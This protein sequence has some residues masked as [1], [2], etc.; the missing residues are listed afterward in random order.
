MAERTLKKA[1]Y[2]GVWTTDFPTESGEYWVW[3]HQ[4][5]AIEGLVLRAWVDIKGGFVLVERQRTAIGVIWSRRLDN[6]DT[7]HWMGPIKRPEPPEDKA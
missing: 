7:C 6:T 3:G 4:F 1:E 5:D 2:Q